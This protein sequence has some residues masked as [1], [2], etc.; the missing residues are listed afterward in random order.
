MGMNNM[1]NG[2]SSSSSSSSA[3]ADANGFQARHHLNL[4][5]PAPPPP[6]PVGDQRLRVQTQYAGADAVRGNHEF[7]THSN[8]P[9]YVQQDAEF[10]SACLE[11]IIQ[12]AH[13]GT[14]QAEIVQQDKVMDL[15]L[16]RQQGGAGMGMGGGNGSGM[17]GGDEGSFGMGGGGY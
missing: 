13:I 8:K 2:S 1:G 11:M 10:Y 17:G 16:G 5:A 15:R 3:A 6:V 7:L 4:D 14:A 9:Q 12:E